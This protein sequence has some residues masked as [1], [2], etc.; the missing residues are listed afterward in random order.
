MDNID[1][2]LES[3]EQKILD[4]SVLQIDYSH[5][6]EL[7][8][9]FVFAYKR[10]TLA[11]S[12]M[13]CQSHEVETAGYII[14]AGNVLDKDIEDEI[15]SIFKTT[16]INIKINKPIDHTIWQAHYCMM[17]EISLFADHLVKGRKYINEK[18]KCIKG[19]MN[20]LTLNEKTNPATRETLEGL[21]DKAGDILNTHLPKG[22]Q[23]PKDVRVWLYTEVYLP[24]FPQWLDKSEDEKNAI[25][26]TTPL[27]KIVKEIV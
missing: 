13:L 11:K 12:Q 10:L 20:I 17:C 9:M 15:D 8:S 25:L 7:I 14:T 5:K 19:V 1:K 16:N 26:T 18:K 23:V 3:L 2:H 4:T 22:G 21:V 24:I 6:E 27:N